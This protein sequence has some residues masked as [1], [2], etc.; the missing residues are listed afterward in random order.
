MTGAK[1]SLRM[2]KDDGLAMTDVNYDVSP[3]MSVD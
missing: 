1:G 3:M 2:T